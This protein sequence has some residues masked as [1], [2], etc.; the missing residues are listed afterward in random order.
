MVTSY[1]PSPAQAHPGTRPPASHS[2]TALHGL[3]WPCA[4]HVTGSPLGPLARAKRRVMG[5]R[6]CGY[7]V[8]R[9][10]LPVTRL[11]RFLTN[12]P[13]PHRC[14]APPP[15]RTPST[16]AH[17]VLALCRR[18]RADVSEQSSP[19]C[20]AASCHRS[21]PHMQP[22]ACSSTSGQDRAARTERGRQLEG[23][24]GARAR[25]GRPAVRR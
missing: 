6:R 20:A 7:G 14:P 3:A 25:V 2:L 13:E 11:A 8:G 24:A 15:A 12:V 19:L 17:A 10:A 18:K 9:D 22:P 21:S 1:Q 23:S 5:R 16:S 4:V